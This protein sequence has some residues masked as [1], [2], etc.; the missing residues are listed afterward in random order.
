[1]HWHLMFPLPC[2]RGDSPCLCGSECPPM[3]RLPAC[4][5]QHQL[6][7]RAKLCCQLQQQRGRRG[8]ATVRAATAVMRFCKARQVREGGLQLV[9]LG[10]GLVC[11]SGLR[12]EAAL[13]AA[14]ICMCCRQTRTAQVQLHFPAS[15]AELLFPELLFPASRVLPLQPIQLSL[16]IG[17]LAIQP[18][19]GTRLADLLRKKS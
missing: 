19:K 4:T 17:W 12:R 13:L 5:S 16:R 7:P 3:A 10:G 8:R 14:G 1:M 9:E 18:I 15:R 2:T 11:M 6:H